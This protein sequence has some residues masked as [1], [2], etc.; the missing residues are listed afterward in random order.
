MLSIGLCHHKGPI[1]ELDWF[2]CLGFNDHAI[3]TNPP[4]RI[5]TIDKWSNGPSLVRRVFDHNCLGITGAHDAVENSRLI[6]TATHFGQRVSTASGQG[7]IQG[8]LSA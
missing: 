5:L 4:V 8:I 2:R 1:G 3:G 7:Q 6:L